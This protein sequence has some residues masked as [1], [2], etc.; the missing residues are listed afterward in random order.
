MNSSDILLNSFLLIL[1]ILLSLF[2]YGPVRHEIAYVSFLPEMND[3][4]FG[5]RSRG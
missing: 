3:S 4:E 5:V 1:Q 2:H